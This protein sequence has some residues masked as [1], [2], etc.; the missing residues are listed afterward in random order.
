MSTETPAFDDIAIGLR[1]EDARSVEYEYQ[2]AR[3]LAVLLKVHAPDLQLVFSGGSALRQA[4]G[5][6]QRLSDDA[7]IRITSETP[8]T[9]VRLRAVRQQLGEALRDAG[10]A[11]DPDDET[12]LRARNNSKYIGFRI[13]FSPI[14]PGEP[15]P[16]LDIEA[17]VSRLRLPP[18]TRAVTSLVSR[19]QGGPPEIADVLC[20]ALE[21][22]AAEK[23]VALMRRISTCAAL[24]PP[25]DDD[26]DLVRHIYD[27]NMLLPVVDR[28]ELG[29]L[30]L[31][32][33]EDD[34]KQYRGKSPLFSETPA[35]AVQVALTALRSD[36][37]WRKA[38]NDYQHTNV[39]GPHLDYAQAIEVI[40]EHA[41][42]IWPPGRA[43][44]G[45][46]GGTGPE[47][48][49]DLAAAEDRDATQGAAWRALLLRKPEL[50]IAATDGRGDAVPALREANQALR[51][52]IE[53]EA[54]FA[55]DQGLT[56]P[57][58]RDAFRPASVPPAQRL[59]LSEQ[60]LKVA[61]TAW[62]AFRDKHLGGVKNANPEL[63]TQARLGAG[64]GAKLHAEFRE[65][66]AHVQ[67][68]ARDLQAQHKLKLERKTPHS[69][70]DRGR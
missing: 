44:S 16:H 53:A 32:I 8:L 11:F 47:L 30:V 46:G 20:L 17:V 12:H 43:P 2:M 18:V 54:R 1:I 19:A 31:E 10:F 22:N 56:L 51:E 14:T 67:D 68:A 65:A 64:P 70:V 50:V 34:R 27:L 66:R 7:D 59:Q 52:R 25:K 21:E 5:V 41:H 55:E 48:K 23:T 9:H 62:A 13:A 45:P 58:P 36:P 38:F 4:H 60:R 39:Y 61:H 29:R 33:T 63:V 69:G 37:V 35:D 6:V 24:G 57:T 42:S 40:A 15:A 26:L 28:A 3:A 49:G